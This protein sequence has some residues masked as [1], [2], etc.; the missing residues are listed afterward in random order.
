MYR[1]DESVK[2]TPPFYI[3]P[4]FKEERNNKIIF[5]CLYYDLTFFFRE[6]KKEKFII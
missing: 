3:Y 1:D 4:P 5:T 2:L 6:G